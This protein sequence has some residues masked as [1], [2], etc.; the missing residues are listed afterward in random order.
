MTYPLTREQAQAAASAA[1]A[2]RDAIQA[3][4]LELDGS[5]GKRLLAG[6][7]LTGGSRDSWDQASAGLA[8]LWDTFT[9]YSAVI[10]RATELLAPPGRRDPAR[11]GEVAKLLNGA[12]VRLTRAVA[13]LGQRAAPPAVRSRSPCS[14]RCARC[15]ARSRR[16]RPWS[17]RPRRCGTRSPTGSGS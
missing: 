10:D 5:F 13:P 8:R 6:A 9:A 3:N 17:P 16:W 15:A 2:E 11:L 4:L 7:T 14:R 1:A 12:S